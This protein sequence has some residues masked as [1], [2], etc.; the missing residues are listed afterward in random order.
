M[1]DGLSWA[2]RAW[3]AL[4]AGQRRAALRAVCGALAPRADKMPPGSSDGMVVGGEFQAS[5]GMAEAARVKVDALAALGLLRGQVDMGVG[6]RPAGKISK[7][8]ALLLEINA[9]S[10]PLMLARADQ[11]FLS[12]RRVIGS[13]AWELPVVPRS[14]AAGARYVHE[15]WACSRFTAQALEAVMPGR[16]RV[17]PHPL[18][19]RPLPPVTQTR[20]D[21]GL[22][23]GV[24]ITTL[25]FSLG[26]S[27]TRKNP[28]AAMQAFARAFGDRDDQLLVI[29]FSGEAAFPA[30]AAQIAAAAGANMRIFTGTW[31]PGRVESLIALSDIVISLHRAEGF[32]LVPAQ[33]MLRGVPVVATAFSGNMDYMDSVSAALVDFCLVPVQ[34]S[35]Q[36]YEPMKG[37]VW[38]EPDVAHAADHLRRLGDDAAARRALGAAGR[39][40][41]ERALDGAAL[42]D[43]LAAN[44][45]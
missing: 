18:G 21:L 42:R 17:V 40:Y 12:G 2:H 44:G 39:A 13:W 28:L 35:A 23:E 11:K 36:I 43:A 26:S 31:P 7:N 33:A 15:V 29:K 9:P 38:A 37:A 4:P 10:L 20:A 41:A 3:R 45:V 27:F 5:T 16:V 25:I 22:P 32:G 14:W 24:V 19:L 8:A 6:R 34:D 1:S 30:E